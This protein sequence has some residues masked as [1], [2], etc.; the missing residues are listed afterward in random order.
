M[1]NFVGNMCY[2]ALWRSKDA[3]KSQPPL[4]RRRKREIFTRALKA[5][6]SVVFSVS[7]APVAYALATF[8]PESSAQ[9]SSRML[10]VL[11]NAPGNAL[12]RWMGKVANSDHVPYWIH[13]RLIATVIRL[14]GIDTS[15]VE[16]PLT[17]YHT[18]QEFFSRRLKPGSR[19]PHAA[20]PL[21]SPCDGELL[22]VGCMGP[23]DDAIVQVK[24]SEYST[25]ELLLTALPPVAAGLRRWYM[26][27]HLRPKDYHRFHSAADWTV[28]ETI[29][30][31][32]TLH[33]V[34]QTASKWIPK[35][36]VQNERV[37]CLGAW[38][39]GGIAIVPVGA[40]CVGSITLG[41][42]RSIAT[43]QTKT[44]SNFVSLFRPSNGCKRTDFDHLLED[45][46]QH[47]LPDC[48]SKALALLDGS[49]AGSPMHRPVPPPHPS[50]VFPL[51]QPVRRVYPDGQQP[52]LAKGDE[53][54]WF[55]W[56]SAIAIVCDLP[57]N[58]GVLVKPLQE[59][60]V[61]QPLC[62]WA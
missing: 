12:S 7:L 31:P 43:N 8:L 47:G 56:G 10:S 22:Q 41:F 6:A 42:D 38:R 57:E 62:G 59:V 39:Y 27:F 26:L 30:V 11:A 54:G 48:D 9:A 58:I 46:V 32:G 33:P 5:A 55:N 34:T 60:H 17:H 50:D 37:V 61:G 52:T 29:N 25:Q 53:M 2:A 13:Q 35:L 44:R 4:L 49:P 15:E 36:F 14:Y 45:A 51:P 28:Q 16:L 18:V 23:G 1:M 19:V 20:A 21:V 40:T 24:G 3:R